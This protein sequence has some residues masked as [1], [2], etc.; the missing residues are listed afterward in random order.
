MMVSTDGLLC[1]AN[2]NTHFSGSSGAC[3]R[4]KNTALPGWGRAVSGSWYHPTSPCPRGSR[5]WSA[6]HDT[7]QRPD[8]GSRLAQLGPAAAY[9]TKAVPMAVRG[10]APR[11]F[12]PAFLVPLCSNRGSLAHSAGYSSSSSLQ[13]SIVEHTLSSGATLVNSVRDVSDIWRYAS[14]NASGSGSELDEQLIGA[15]SA[16]ERGEPAQN[17]S[18]VRSCIGS[19][20]RFGDLCRAC[21]KSM[22]NRLPRPDART[23]PSPWSACDRRRRRG[24][25]A[26]AIESGCLSTLD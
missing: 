12:S 8:N 10:G 11:S 6:S 1:Q 4:H 7:M 24:A 17:L 22:C 9:Q 5:P 23:F 3:W 20:Q 16:G 26:S 14:A 25:F 19:R 18:A 15:L 13:S 2:D 21:S